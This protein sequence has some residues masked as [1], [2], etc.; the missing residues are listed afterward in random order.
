MSARTRLTF[1]INRQ[2]YSLVMWLLSPLVL[3]RLLWR[4]RRHAGYRR[5]L[6]HRI[7]LYGTHNTVSPGARVWIHAVSVGETVAVAPL[8]ERLLQQ[9]P[10][11][12][13]LVTSTTPT[14][15]EQV[16]RQF[17]ERVAS[18]W[19][20]IDTP[21]ATRRFFAHW[22]PTIGVLIETEIWPNMIEQ[23]SLRGVPMLLLNA[24]LSARSA[25]G[26][27][28]LPG[29]IRQALQG[30]SGIAAQERADGRRL[31]ALGANPDRLSTTGNLKFAVNVASL[32]QQNEIERAVLGSE[33][34]GR[35]VWLAASTHPGEEEA[36]IRAFASLKAAVPTALLMLAPR[37]PERVPALLAIPE[38]QGRTAA[39][40]STQSPLRP[41]TDLLLI[42]TLGHLG[43]L[44]GCADL[45]FVGGSL[46][47]HGG[48][49]PL[50]AAAWGLPIITGPH[51]VNFSGVYRALFRAGAARRVE[52]SALATTLV[53]L[54]GS[55][56]RNAELARMGEC[57]KA[58]QSAQHGV[59]DR[60]WA[61]LQAHLP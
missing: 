37:H 22:R 19:A 28:R 29:L 35:P 45:V 41:E 23:A 47:P 7:G 60:Q 14:G 61:I 1:P 4:S 42:D 49:N 46:V 12:E 38:I 20:P 44:T 54:L 25:R 17:G 18:D 9:R 55:G 5:N 10:D 57:A 48:H 2:L 24:R 33:I 50:E 16:R 30:L 3:A 11:L 40:Y 31:R 52:E 34:E 36:I 13:V 21:Q 26:Y 56:G 8:L 58:V 43:A 27:A 15:V 6:L 53:E 51:Y 59:L 39:L 32:E